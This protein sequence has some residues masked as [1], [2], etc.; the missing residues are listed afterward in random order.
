MARFIPPQY[1]FWSVSSGAHHQHVKSRRWNQLLKLYFTYYFYR[2]AAGGFVSWLVYCRV[3]NSVIS[4]SKPFRWIV[5]R[6]YWRFESWVVSGRWYCPVHISGKRFTFCISYQRTGWTW[7]IK[8][9][10]KNIWNTEWNVEKNRWL[11]MENRRRSLW[12]YGSLC[13]LNRYCLLWTLGSPLSKD[14][15]NLDEDIFCLFVIFFLV[16]LLMV[17]CFVTRLVVCLN[18][19]HK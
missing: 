16:L 19:M 3:C 2:E 15:C 11:K 8:R 4:L 9:W 1:N 6:V 14:L 5:I 12:K 18:L 7:D 13:P 10:W 17:V